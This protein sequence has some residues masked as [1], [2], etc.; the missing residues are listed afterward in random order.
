MGLLPYLK[1]DNMMYK[2]IVNAEDGIQVSV[3]VGN[4]GYYH[5]NNLVIWDERRQGKIPDDMIAHIGYLKVK[6]SKL[7]IDEI[8]KKSHDIHMKKEDDKKLLEECYMLR[9]IAYGRMGDQFD[10]IYHEGIDAWKA[11]IK[12]V[13]DK[14]PKPVI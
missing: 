13:K 3:M 5:N 2:L 12:A 1:K 9:H 6:S 8:R 10:K 4:T 14:Y 7:I 11:D